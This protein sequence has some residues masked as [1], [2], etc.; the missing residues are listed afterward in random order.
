MVCVLIQG[1]TKFPFSFSNVSNSN[2]ATIICRRRVG[3]YVG[4]EMEMAKWFPGFEM[5]ASTARQGS[6]GGRAR[7]TVR[8]NAV[9][10]RR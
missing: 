4:V 8:K 10:Q 2:N 3:T 1:T 5:Q 9:R 6:C 7:R